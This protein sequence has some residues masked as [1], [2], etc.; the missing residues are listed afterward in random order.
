M[1]TETLQNILI[2][3]LRK[4]EQL[5]EAGQDL[6]RDFLST[7]GLDREDAVERVTAWLKSSLVTSANEMFSWVLAEDEDP[8]EAEAVV[9]YPIGGIERGLARAFTELTKGLDPSALAEEIVEV[10][11]D[12]LRDEQ[13]PCCNDFSCPCGGSARY[14]F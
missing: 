8:E 12:Q 5:L 10:A 11:E 1:N 4:D 2:D 13:Q 7:S 9:G 6:A 14:G 3:G